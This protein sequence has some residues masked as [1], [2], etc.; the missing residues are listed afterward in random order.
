LSTDFSLNFTYRF[1]D[2]TAKGILDCRLEVWGVATM[3]PRR[4]SIRAD[5]RRHERTLAGP[6]IAGGH[7]QKQRQT[8][9]DWCGD[10]WKNTGSDRSIS[11]HKS[12]NVGA[13]RKRLREF[14]PVWRARQDSY[15]AGGCQA[16]WFLSVQR[17]AITMTYSCPSPKS[18]RSCAAS[19]ATLWGKSRYEHDS[20]ESTGAHTR[21]R[22]RRHGPRCPMQRARATAHVRLRVVRNDGVIRRLPGTRPRV[23]PSACER[24]VSSARPSPRRDAFAP[25]DN[26]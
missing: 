8:R 19:S 2:A 15:E 18:L 13:M 11:V 5:S 4:R 12:P 6:E 24:V 23:L 1:I 9:S 16:P 25:R 7:A 20:Q 22:R 10:L 17:F 26:R 21:G 14:R 3:L